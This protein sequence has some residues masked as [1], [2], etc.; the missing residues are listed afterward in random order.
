MNRLY[1]LVLASLI[2]FLG[3][4]VGSA[5]SM[6][7]TNN[8]VPTENSTLYTAPIVLNKTM[9]I[10]YMIKDNTTTKYGIIKHEITGTNRN[11]TIYPTISFNGTALSLVFPEN[12]YYT[13]NGKMPTNKSTLYTSPIILDKN[14]IVKYLIV[15][16]GTK[17]TGIVKHTPCKLV[18]KVQARKMNHKWVKQVI[19][20]LV[21]A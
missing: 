7:Y 8:S 11:R 13:V 19:R 14:M 10:K 1:A 15:V 2:L 20:E 9:Q 18:K 16:N 3:I 17:Y 21:P 6:F 12:V 4:G 5:A